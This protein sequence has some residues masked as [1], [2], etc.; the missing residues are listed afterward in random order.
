M[1]SQTGA[2]FVLV[3]KVMDKPT[4]GTATLK[5]FEWGFANGDKS[6]DDLDY[7]TLP[8]S[9]KELIRKQGATV[10]DSAG[11]PVALK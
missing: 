1:K 6:A 2:T 3:H 10:K 8:D 11:K 4:E 9:V 5:F 7:I